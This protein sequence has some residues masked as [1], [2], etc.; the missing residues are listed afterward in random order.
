MLETEQQRVSNL[1]QQLLTEQNTTTNLRRQLN[2]AQT[3]AEALQA[4]MDNKQREVDTLRQQL[5]TVQ[6]QVSS[7]QQQVDSVQA[8]SVHLDRLDTGQR[9]VDNGQQGKVVRLDTNRSR[10]SG[11]QDTASENVMAEQIR[12][13]LK[14]EPGLSGRQIAA[15]LGCSPTTASRWK[16][17]IENGGTECVNE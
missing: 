1:Q 7:L 2:I 13:L 17:I 10:K 6:Q 16:G 11:Q 4:Q 5:S 12:Q 3:N 9:K 14:A 8:S 15:R